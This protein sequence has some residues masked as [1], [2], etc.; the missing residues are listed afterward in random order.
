MLSELSLRTFKCFERL[1]LPLA[2][3]TL[4]TGTNA[5]GKSSVIQALALLHQSLVDTNNRPLILLDGSLFSLGTA[6][7]VID[8]ITGRRSFSIGI[9]QTT[10]GGPFWAEWTA[11]SDEVE[12][13]DIAIPVTVMR[14]G[15]DVGCWIQEHDS[16][17]P[18][19][20]GQF[21]V[22]LPAISSFEKAAN[23]AREVRELIERMT[24]LSAERMGP[25]ET[26]PLKNPSDHLT[27][28]ALGEGTAGT[29]YW[30]GEQPVQD[31]LRRPEETP[32]LLKQANAWLSEFFPGATFEVQRVPRANRV[33]LGFRTSRDTTYLRPQNVGFGLTNVLPILVAALHARPGDLLL[34]ENPEAHLHPAGQAKMGQFLARVAATGVQVILETHSDHVLN[35]VRRA[36]RAGALAPRSVAIH[37]F[38]AR[39][40]SGDPL[41]SRVITPSLDHEGNIDH[42]PDGFFDQ[43]DK[44]ASYLAGWGE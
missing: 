16:T 8:Q 29:L 25:R 30:Y 44:D 42:W 11:T 17:P 7:D 41:L 23:W 22:D 1:N 27:V 21:V 15:H 6:A 40:E 20:P 10:T 12:R 38:Q 4:L 14:L 35:G 37:F 36:V 39:M 34:L 3:L 28:G 31:A 32:V 19:S 43:F 24:Y 18:T 26:Y 5:S 2:E 33:T 13:Q 9:A